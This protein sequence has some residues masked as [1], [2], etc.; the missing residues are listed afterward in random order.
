MNDSPNK[1]RPSFET[2]IAPARAETLEDNTLVIM[3][4]NDFSADWL[5]S[6][7]SEIITSAVREVTGEPEFEVKFICPGADEFPLLPTEPR[8]SLYEAVKKIDARMESLERKV[9][10]LLAVLPKKDS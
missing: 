2:W 10:Q 5:A 7:Y 1:S 6:H 9:D 4:P 3:A 8:E